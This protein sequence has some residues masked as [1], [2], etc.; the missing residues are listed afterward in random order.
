MINTGSIN[1]ER[2]ITTL[3]AEKKD[4][5]E[6]EVSK[7]KIVLDE[8]EKNKIEDSVKLIPIPY[9]DKF[10]SF[11]NYIYLQQKIKIED[12][13]IPCRVCGLPCYQNEIREELCFFCYRESEE[14]IKSLRSLFHK[15]LAYI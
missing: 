14:W 7:K 12:G 4:S 9:K 6:G 2:E 11:I 8:K 13:A 5:I 1:Q 3:L 15:N 10:R